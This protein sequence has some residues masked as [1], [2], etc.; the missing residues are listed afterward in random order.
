[1]KWKNLDKELQVIGEDMVNILIDSL[2]TYGLSNSKLAKNI[3]Y[4]IKDQLVVISMPTYGYFLDEGTKPHMPPVDAIKKWAD[5]KG[6]NAWAVAMNIKKYGTKAK[7][8]IYT[9]YNATKKL[10]KRIADAGF[11]DVLIETDNIFMKTF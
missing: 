6:L 10:D 8:F 11:S 4:K 5:N 9:L 1:M 2:S 7:P 3:K